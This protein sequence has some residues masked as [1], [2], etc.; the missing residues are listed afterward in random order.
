MLRDIG[1][2]ANLNMC[3]FWLP[4]FQDSIHA[5]ERP[6]RRR[7]VARSRRKRGFRFGACRN[8]LGHVRSAADPHH[9]LNRRPQYAVE[10]KTI[11]A[12]APFQARRR[13]NKILPR[14]ANRI[15]PADPARFTR[16][17]LRWPE[18]RAFAT[19][20]REWSH[21]E[22]TGRA[23][24]SFQ[25]RRARMLRRRRRQLH[26]ADRVPQHPVGFASKLLARAPRAGRDRDC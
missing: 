13:P 26:A 6:R 2:L 3:Q 1:G 4:F 14:S 19:L 16:L 11:R 10:R 18:R 7:H 22:R 17:K 25:Q 23:G 24:C 9:P 20:P 8:V 21:R 12:A 15:G 5:L